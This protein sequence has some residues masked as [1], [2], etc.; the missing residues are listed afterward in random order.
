MAHNAS[1]S[2][3]DKKL[4]EAMSRA[5]AAEHAAAESRAVARDVE[6]ALAAA[7]DLAASVADAANPRGWTPPARDELA[8]ARK[9][10][11][12]GDA[13]RGGSRQGARGRRGAKALAQSLRAAHANRWRSSRRSSPPISPR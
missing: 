6:A 3:S 12:S 2:G 4:A 5:A 10:H 11:K 7:K 1:L 13:R 8:A 9:A